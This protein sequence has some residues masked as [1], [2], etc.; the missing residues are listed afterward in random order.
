MPWVKFDKSKHATFT[1]GES[2]MG[3]E[4]VLV[5][6]NNFRDQLDKHQREEYAS[7]TTN[8]HFVTV[9]ML[10]KAR[11]LYAT[12]TSSF[13]QHV[14][15]SLH[16]TWGDQFMRLVEGRK[17]RYVPTRFTEVLLP[18][19]EHMSFAEWVK[20]TFRYRIVPEG[21]EP[22]LKAP[23]MRINARGQVYEMFA[24][25]KPGG[26]FDWFESTV[27]ILKL[28]PGAHGIVI[29]RN[30]EAPATTGYAGSAKKA[31]IDFDAMRDVIRACATERWDRAAAAAGSQTWEPFQVVW[32]RYETQKYSHELRNT[33]AREW[34]AQPA[35]KAILDDCHILPGSTV[36]LSSQPTTGIIDASRIENSQWDQL[37]ELERRAS[38]LVWNDHSERGIDPLALSRD[39]YVQRFG[40][41]RLLGYGEVIV[42]GELSEE[43][44]EIRL[45]NSVAEE[46][47]ITLACV[48][49]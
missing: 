13:L 17:I 38:D 25:S 22:D 21:E 26:F 11:E 36:R 1:I 12:G 31:A 45:F 6:G 35:V 37:I 27:D 42:D 43:S 10:Q 3:H 30:E 40:L 49:S 46:A 28:K 24:Q 32:K 34:A 15:G 8:R 4:T 48:H 41:S 5:I 23:W 2:T 9:D 44:D 14:D 19:K 16:D 20:K 7:P 29:D 33:A 18:T 39:Q 47:V